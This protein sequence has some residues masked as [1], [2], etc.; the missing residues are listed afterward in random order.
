ML[1][2]EQNIVNAAKRLRI[3]KAIMNSNLTIETAPTISSQA[4][5]SVL[6]LS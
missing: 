5:P 2:L 1:R 4:C 6:T 3:A